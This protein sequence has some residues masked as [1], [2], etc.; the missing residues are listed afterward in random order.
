MVASDDMAWRLVIHLDDRVAR[1][2]VAT[3][4][5]VLGSHSESGIRIDHPTVSRRHA[6]LTVADDGAALEDLGSRNGLW[7]G[8]SRVERHAL[9]PGEPVSIG[10][11]SVVLEEV[12]SGD[13]SAA[14]VLGGAAPAVAEPLAAQG[15]TTFGSGPAEG[16]ALQALPEL[17][18]R[19]S[20]G[21][22]RNRMAQAAGEAVYRTLPCSETLV[23]NSS[24]GGT[25]FAASRTSPPSG[26]PVTC[27]ANA[28]GF[29]FRVVF[30]SPRIAEVCRPLLETAA[31]LVNLAEREPSTYPKAGR[32]STGAPRLPDPPSV[33][34]AVRQLYADATRVARGD[35]GVL[36]LG[37]SGTGKE[38]LARYLHAASRR[39]QG[40]FLG[41]NCAALPSDLLEAELFGIEKG[42]ATGVDAR[43]GRFELADAGTLFLDEIGD[44]ALDTQ[45]KILRVLQS[46]EVYRLGGQRPRSVRVRIVAATNRDVRAMLGDGRFREDLFHRI[47]TWVVELPPLRHRRADIVNLAAHFLDKAAATNG[48]AIGGISRAALDT[49][50]SFSWPGN[51]RQLENEMQRAALFIEDGELL[52]TGRLSEEVRRG[53]PSGAAANLEEILE[54]VERDEIAL[55]LEAV[56]GVVET[57]AERLGVSRATLYRRM[58]ALDISTR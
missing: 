21:A 26:E 46:G 9:V 53:R 39:A 24:T 6:R 5:H 34:P 18:A 27:D 57:A 29:R 38:V 25:V 1:V 54:R 28:A 51:I 37:E 33:V 43:S 42:V 47:A 48:V 23:T 12:A 58:K 50:E 11:V 13:L 7:V 19:L 36:I 31:R 4:Q 2:P 52:D 45:A 17:V 20:E 30:P 35:V 8:S 15:H 56:G 22:G 3:G 55:A 40:P 44:M 16:F 49:L 41:L 32:Q 14:V 10:A